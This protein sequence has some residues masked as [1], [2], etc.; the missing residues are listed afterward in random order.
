MLDPIMKHKKTD[1]NKARKERIIN[2]L[3]DND[4]KSIICIQVARGILLKF[5]SFATLFQTNKPMCHALHF[6]IFKLVKTFFGCF[7]DPEHL[8]DYCAKQLG[9]INVDDRNMYLSDRHLS[10]G[11]YC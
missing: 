9:D 3:F 8:P 4:E 5:Q 7:I 2:A 11:E 1:A 6:E 10:V